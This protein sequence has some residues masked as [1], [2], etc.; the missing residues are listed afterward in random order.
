LGIDE[1]FVPPAPGNSGC[2]LG[3]GMLVWHHAMQKPRLPAVRYM[4]RGPACDRSEVKDV[5]DNCKARYSHQT[6]V[7]RKLDATLQLL[8]SGKIVGWFQGP[9]SSDCGHLETVAY[10]P[11]PGP[12]T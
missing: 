7:E 11:G 12:H 6:T 4:Y 8:M 9:L 10:W 2:S 5:L 3:A 1:V